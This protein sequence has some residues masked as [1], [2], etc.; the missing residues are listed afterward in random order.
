MEKKGMRFLA[1]IILSAFL[2][3]AYRPGHSTSV[4]GI[5]PEKP[6]DAFGF[7]AEV[8]NLQPEFR[9]KESGLEGSTYDFAIWRANPNRDAE[10]KQSWGELVYYVE[11][12]ETHH[13][14]VDMK[15]LPNT[16]YCWSVRERR[17][18]DK[19]LGVWSNRSLTGMTGRR[20]NIPFYFKTP[21]NVLM[22]DVGP[23]ESC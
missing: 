18:K 1:L 2:G 20:T 19:Y 21:R 22:P 16:V 17:M 4:V 13:H 10:G 7:D 23:V 12:L 6:F 8:E 15:L 14:V 9:W 5:E 11:D 3:C